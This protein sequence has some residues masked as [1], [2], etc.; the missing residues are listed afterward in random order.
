MLYVLLGC[1]FTDS[2][3]E[4]FPAEENQQKKINQE[5][6]S[7]TRIMGKAFRIF[8]HDAKVDKC[9]VANASRYKCNLYNIALAIHPF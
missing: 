9:T 6:F 8:L 5:T 2:D 4:Y 3:E 7:S 1:L